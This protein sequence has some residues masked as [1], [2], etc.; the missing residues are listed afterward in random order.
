MPFF[1]IAVIFTCITGYYLEINGETFY[2]LLNAKLSFI[3]N[4]AW[5]LVCIAIVII[6]IK[7]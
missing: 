2:E 1:A 6:I 4:F 5:K 7:V 3:R